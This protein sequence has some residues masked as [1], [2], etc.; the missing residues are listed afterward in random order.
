MK[1]RCVFC[2]LLAVSYFHGR[3]LKDPTYKKPR[4]TKFAFDRVFSP[5]ATNIE[6]YEQTTKTVL[7]DLVEGYNCSGTLMFSNCHSNISIVY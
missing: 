5:S 6:V 1:Y 2:L 7:R 3:A 4:D